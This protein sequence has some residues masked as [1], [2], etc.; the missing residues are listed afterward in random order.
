MYQRYSDKSPQMMNHNTTGRMR[1]LYYKGREEKKMNKLNLSIQ[2]MVN[3]KLYNEKSA[4]LT[5]SSV[6]KRI[7]NFVKTKNRLS[8]ESNTQ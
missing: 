8:Y 5:A 1:D 4:P 2:K 6:N 7:I 3:A